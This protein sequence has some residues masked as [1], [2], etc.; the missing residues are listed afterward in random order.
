[1]L[2]YSVYNIQ[3]KKHPIEEWIVVSGEIRNET[4]KNFNTAVFHLKVFI[5]QS[6]L[7]STI[8]KIRGFRAKASKDFE[9]L[10]EGVHHELLK[11]VLRC[12]IFFES[13]Y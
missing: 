9:V 7:G 13:A 5:G 6:C 8:I 3:F 1:M 4:S 2:N 10:V 11:Q 12:D